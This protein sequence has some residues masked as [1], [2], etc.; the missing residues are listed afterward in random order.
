MCFSS[1][2]SSPAP[3]PVVYADPVATPV[4][5][6]TVEELKT[7]EDLALADEEN[8]AKKGVKGLRKDL[9]NSLATNTG[10]GTGINILQ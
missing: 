3:A 1:K 9:T 2:K 10:G 7:E 8:K 5:P 6:T 4:A